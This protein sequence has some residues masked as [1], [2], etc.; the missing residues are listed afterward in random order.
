M[1]VL[2]SPA[3]SLD[4]TSALPEFSPSRP[5][6]A[7]EATAL[8][9]HAAKLGAAKLGKLMGISD[10]LAALNAERGIVILVFHP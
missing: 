10:K 1:I 7:E 4:Y 3:K 6:F 8:A 2:L 5:R 9:A